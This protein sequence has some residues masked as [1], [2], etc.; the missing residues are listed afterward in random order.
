MRNIWLFSPLVPFKTRERYISFAQLVLLSLYYKI[1]KYVVSTDKRTDVWSRDFL[2][3]K[4][5]FGL[6]AVARAGLW[7]KKGL[8]RL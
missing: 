6:W 5:N 7:E 4:I 3:R 8:G 1:A 2:I